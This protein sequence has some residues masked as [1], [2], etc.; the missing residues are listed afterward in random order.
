MWDGGVKNF[1]LK[2]STYKTN[3]P[4]SFLILPTIIAN[5]QYDL[6]D[7]YVIFTGTK[8]GSVKTSHDKNKYTYCNN[9]KY[10]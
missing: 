1:I 6:K 8:G 2:V 7:V 10:N 4:F 3:M 9:N 5:K